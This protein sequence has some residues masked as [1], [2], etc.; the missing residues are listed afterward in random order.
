VRVP[1]L[2]LLV[3][4]ILVGVLTGGVY[5]L[6][7]SGLTLIFGVMR[8]INIAHGAF[9]ILGAYLAYW[10]F[11][12]NG[13]DP[14]LSILV[15]APLFFVGG[16]LIQ[17][18]V[19]SRMRRD[20]G[21]VVLATFAMAI[22]LAGTMGAFWESTFRSVRTGYTG[23][24]LRFE[25]LGLGIRLPVVRLF[26]FAGAV[27]VLGLLYWVLARSDLGRGIRA[28]I[29]NPEAAQLV[30]VNVSRVQALTFG[31]GMATAAAGGALFSEIWSFN[32]D[33]HEV[34]IS[35]MLAIIV[36]G[37]MGSLPGA[38]IAAVIMGV[39]EAVASVTL[40]TYLSP[41]VFYVILFLTLIFRPRGLLGARIR[42][43]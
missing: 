31:L 37:G 20:P 8:V 28:T 11:R 24:V 9:L 26:G 12:N 17:R 5:A 30:G 4:V 32:A 42:E 41:I 6:M 23:N 14:A 2:N 7:A 18:H 34:W 10:L 15:S 38:L 21:M 1:S 27:V 25:L 13:L 16:T 22:V 19:L 29:Q 36:L 39:A 33:S 40:T 3:Q 35:K 43:G